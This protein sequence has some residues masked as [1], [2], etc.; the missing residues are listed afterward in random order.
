MVVVFAP[1]LVHGWCVAA[2][3][4]G[5]MN[6]VPME[7][8]NISAEHCLPPAHGLYKLHGHNSTGGTG[9]HECDLLSPPLPST[10]LCVHAP[11]KDVF[12][13]RGIVW[14]G[15]WTDRCNNE[16]RLRTLCRIVRAVREASLR[17]KKPVWV[18]DVGANIGT[19][20][21]PL[22]AAGVN[23]ASFE[24]DASNLRLLRGSVAAQRKLHAADRL[25]ASIVVAGALSDTVGDE[26]CLGT[27][28]AK[29]GNEVNSGSVRVEAPGQ[30]NCRQRTRTTT[31]DAALQ[32]ILEYQRSTLMPSEEPGGRRRAVAGSSAER[33]LR[34]VAMKMDVQGYESHV[35]GGGA[36][37]LRESPPETIFI[38]SKNTTLIA[39]LV[40]AGYV[41]CGK[42]KDGCDYNVR[43]ERVR[44]SAAAT[45]TSASNPIVHDPLRQP[46]HRYFM[47]G[48]HA[49]H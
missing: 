18:L 44:R 14:K 20:T 30:V 1:L 28:A 8:Q 35:M 10:W 25:G 12:I 48:A 49:K 3:R 38:E 22:L 29:H 5:A 46:H 33:S 11:D 9:T 42:F 45:D 41:Q 27:V 23:V 32:T 6:P 19:F 17:S 36:R 40:D 43:L 15:G 4:K 16:Y 31:L 39:S 2:C 37:L 13:S 26:L 24:A 34:V 47:C 21:L 7:V